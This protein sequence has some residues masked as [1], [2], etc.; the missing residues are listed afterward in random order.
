MKILGIETKKPIE[1][2]ITIYKC[3]YC[4]KKFF[5]KNS[6]RN[7]ITKKY[8]QYLFIDFEIKTNL[9]KENKINTQEY[10]EWCYEN[11]YIEFCNI[12]IE[13]KKKLSKQFFD[14][15]ESLYKNSED[16]Y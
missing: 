5:N 7:H 6:I 10:Y 16:E 15:I 14:K 11:G 2:N 13:E 1:E 8:C 4:H 9:Y 12:T 3:P